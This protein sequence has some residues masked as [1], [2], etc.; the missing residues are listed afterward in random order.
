M[1]KQYFFLKLNP[2]RPSFSQDMTKEEREIMNKHV[3]YWTGLMSKDVVYVYG[4]VL[5][6]KGGYGIGV[7]EV[8]SEEQVK[9][10]MANDPAAKSGLGWYEYFP[11]RAIVQKNK[12]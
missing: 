6:P 10:L 12:E 11:M 3:E 5:D 1:E 9:E 8:D 4:P 2:P 7:V